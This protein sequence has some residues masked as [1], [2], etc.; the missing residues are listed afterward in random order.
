M[1]METVSF[2]TVDNV[3]LRGLFFTPAN[4]S[5]EKL[6][7]VIISHGFSGVKEGGL[8]AVAEYF[9]A[10][11][12]ITCLVF[13]NRGFG[14]S[15]T[16]VGQP[17]LEVDATAQT[18]DI[19]DAITYSQTRP[20]AVVSQAPLMDGWSCFANLLRAD[21]LT[22]WEADF[23]KDRIGRAAGKPP[24]MIPVV[25]PNPLNRSAMTTKD[26]NRAMTNNENLFATWKNEVT[27]KSMENLRAHPAAAWI[28]RI[29]PTPLLLS[30]AANDAVTPTAT[31]L[32]AF[33]RALEPK[34]LHVFEGGHYEA[35]VGF[36]NFENCVQ[37]QAD[38][39]KRK[40]CSP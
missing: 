1:G 2:Q 31:T 11:L 33:N 36:P 37:V 5:G 28:H 17:R 4:Y 10:N 32:E 15:D 30:V 40:L 34:E 19:S 12:H 35:Y 23:Q 39:F 16:G 9:T 8:T 26:S 3:T 27:L 38:F 14:E 24:M 21:E 7:C 13:D 6:P 18:N 20:E 29:S 25:D 22:D